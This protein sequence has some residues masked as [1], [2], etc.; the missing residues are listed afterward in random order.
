MG[1]IE[2]WLKKLLGPPRRGY[3]PP[4]PPDW[5]L[6]RE[7]PHR[8][9]YR[10]PGPKERLRTSKTFAVKYQVPATYASVLQ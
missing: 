3:R 9:G 7:R 6:R 4:R 2:G 8:E 1:T 10:P 5:R